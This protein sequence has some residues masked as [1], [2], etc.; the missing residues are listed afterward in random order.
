MQT[1]KTNSIIVNY[2]SRTGEYIVSNGTTIKSLIFSKAAERLLQ[3]HFL[4]PCDISLGYNEKQAEKFLL[5]L[6]N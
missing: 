2:N 6:F 4:M 5:N 3:K 1:Q